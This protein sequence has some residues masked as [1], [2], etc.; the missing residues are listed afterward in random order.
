MVTGI[1]ALKPMVIDA[2]PPCRDHRGCPPSSASPAPAR[3]APASRS[4][5]AP[6]G[7]RTLLYDPLPG[8]AERGAERVIEGLEGAKARGKLTADEVRA[9][10][11]RLERRRRARG[12]APCE[13]VIEAAPE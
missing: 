9:A 2:T 5:P 3:W 4:S 11:E 6:S 12:L 8:A 10:W 1:D 13:L 7:A